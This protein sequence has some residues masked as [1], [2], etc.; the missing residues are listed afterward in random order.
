MGWLV[1]AGLIGLCLAL[2]LL[3]RR[4]VDARGLALLRCFFPSWRFFEEIEPGPTLHYCVAGPNRDFGDWRVALRPRKRTAAALI[5]NAP[6]NL[7]LAQQSL[8]EELWSAWDDAGGRAP[9][10]LTAYALVAA[11][12]RAEVLRP[13]ERVPG[14]RFRFRL[15]ATGGPD[16][17]SETHEV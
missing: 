6:G 4:E 9:S 10:E 15:R 1:A 7:A 11:L 14:A 16:L 8:V 17:S 5:L 12:V 2:V 13:E 3:P